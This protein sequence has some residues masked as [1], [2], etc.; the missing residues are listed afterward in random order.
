MAALD[1]VMATTT[2][3]TPTASSSPASPW[4]AAAPGNSPPLTP[5]SFSAVVPICGP[6][7]LD[8]VDA[9]KNLPF[10]STTATKTAS[11]PSRTSAQ[12]VEAL[13]K[14][15]GNARLTEYRGVGHNSWDRAYSDPNLASWMLSQ[16][17]N[18]Q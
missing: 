10:E 14:A 15:G 11:P 17:R 3:S 18:S 1:Q 8:K 9:L 6:G 7:S 4:A 5:A 16:R 2:R 12:M 13:Q